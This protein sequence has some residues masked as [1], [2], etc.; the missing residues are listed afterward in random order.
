MNI[1][2]VL[3]FFGM[4]LFLVTG[5]LFL[6][7]LNSKFELRF[8]SRSAR[9]LSSLAVLAVLF[10]VSA[11]AA[12][13]PAISNYTLLTIYAVVLYAYTLLCLKGSLLQ[14]LFWTLIAIAIFAISLTV[15]NIYMTIAF[16]ELPEGYMLHT[17]WAMT[18]VSIVAVLI[19]F[20]ITYLFARNKNQRVQMSVFTMVILIVI[21]LLSGYILAEMSQY[22]MSVYPDERVATLLVYIS[23]GVFIINLAVFALYELMSGLTLRT[24]D[25]EAE[26]QRTALEKVHHTEL[27]SLYNETRA[28]RHDY[29]N[30]LE[31]ITGLAKAE[32]MQELMDYLSGIDASLDKIDFR[33]RTG[34]DLLDAIVNAK[35]S[36]AEAKSIRFQSNVRR[37]TLKIEPVDVTTL[38]GNLLDNAIEACERIT[39]PDANRYVNL[40]IY[41]I[42]E[43]VCVCV[44]NSTNGDVKQENGV[45]ATSKREP[46]HGIGT[47][48]I[49]AIVEKYGGYISRNVEKNA[50]EVLVRLP[51]PDGA[52]A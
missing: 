45:F 40:E 27:E 51:I 35:I 50:F 30:H 46:N 15:S 44:S 23:I 3:S 19:Q 21:P 38:V 8:T 43:Q 32:K 9:T 31:V 25:Q 34:S 2:G 49:D 47:Q 11:L 48:Q 5:R 33:I 39:D 37:I 52:G 6:Y 26:L 41:E 20:V 18:Q 1:D 28:W 13:P 12:I 17:S 14:K 24:L 16:G 7:L 29:R 10:I 4:A 42:M 22:G 36:R